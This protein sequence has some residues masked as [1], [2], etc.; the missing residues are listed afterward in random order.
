MKDVV[1]LRLCAT[2]LSVL[3]PLVLVIRRVAA[4]R[5]LD[6]LRAAAAFS[7][8]LFAAVLSRAVTPSPASCHGASLGTNCGGS[9]CSGAFRLIYRSVYQ[10][11]AKAIQYPS[12]SILEI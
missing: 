6:D 10:A 2:T 8:F 1:L 12:I 4:R 7:V 11:G 5:R 3:L 9:E